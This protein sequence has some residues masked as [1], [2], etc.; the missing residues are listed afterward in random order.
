MSEISLRS[1]PASD[2]SDAASLDVGCAGGGSIAALRRCG[3]DADVGALP[4]ATITGMGS[5]DDGLAAGAVVVV[6]VVVVVDPG[7]GGSAR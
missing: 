7:G 3:C 5:D 4:V 1:L 2:T 6:V